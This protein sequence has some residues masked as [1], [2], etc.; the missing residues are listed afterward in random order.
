MNGFFFVTGCYRGQYRNGVRSGYGIRTS[1]GY[2]NRDKEP[3]KAQDV[4][5]KQQRSLSA[6]AAPPTN[7]KRPSIGYD[8]PLPSEDSESSLQQ[9]QNPAYQAQIYEGEWKEDRRHGYGVMKCIG[10]Y[11]Y[12]GQWEKNARTGYGVMR[13]ENG[14]KEEGQ[15]QNGELIVA[16]KRKKLHFRSHQLETNIQTAHTNAI[17]AA[18]SARNKALLAES[19]ASS[20]MAKA[21]IAH[22]VAMRAEKEAQ[23]ARDKAELYK[24]STRVA[25]KLYMV[26]WYH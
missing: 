3:M 13:Y 8:Q 18:E 4:L 22:T 5:S 20:A 24:N 23:I 9:Q 1:A 26:L 12:Y 14:I 15:W 2:E 6:L 19:R 7:L 25:G 16:L 21:K 17:Q 11:T 10:S